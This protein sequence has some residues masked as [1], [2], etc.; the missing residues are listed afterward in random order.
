M[1][2]HYCEWSCLLVRKQRDL[3]NANY[4]TMIR[5]GILPGAYNYVAQVPA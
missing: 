3:Q 4:S 5:I 1:H 2:R